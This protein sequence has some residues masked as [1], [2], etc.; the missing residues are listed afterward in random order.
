MNACL[1]TRIVPAIVAFC[2]L[3]QII[4]QF[5]GIKMYGKISMPG[6]LVF[7][8]LTL[9]TFSTNL[10]I[11]TP[12]CHVFGK[13]VEVKRI[14]RSR[15]TQYCGGRCILNR[16]IKFSLFSP[17]FDMPFWHALLLKPSCGF[18]LISDLSSRFCNWSQF[19]ICIFFVSIPTW[20]L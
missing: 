14:S 4:C 12:A 6:F 5:V 18:L 9:D 16:E 20:F 11:F 17:W 2:P 3:A 13:S 7:P 10:I 15:A 1:M 19:T 8:L